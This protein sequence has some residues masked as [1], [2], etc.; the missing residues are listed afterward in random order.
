[1]KDDVAFT[2]YQVLRRLFMYVI[3]RKPHNH[4]SPEEVSLIP[5]FQMRKRRCR[6]VKC[7]SPGHG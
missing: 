4:P 2:V 7:V 5:V 3:S 6:E 1:M